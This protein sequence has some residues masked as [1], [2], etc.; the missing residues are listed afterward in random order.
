MYLQP[1]LFFLPSLLLLGT[2]CSTAIWG[3]FLPLSFLSYPFH[4]LREPALLD[5]PSPWTLMS[6]NV[7]LKCNAGFSFLPQSAHTCHFL[8]LESLSYFFCTCHHSY[9]PFRPLLRCC[10][11]SY[12]FADLLS[13]NMVKPIELSFSWPSASPVVSC[14]MYDLLTR[15]TWPLHSQCLLNCHNSRPSIAPGTLNICCWMK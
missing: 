8:C 4:L 5:Y 6:R 2:T 3:P 1:Y 15:Q 12:D 7:L 9:A 13:H 10:L 14:S 11:L